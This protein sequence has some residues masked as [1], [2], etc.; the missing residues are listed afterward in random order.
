MRF[1]RENIAILFLCAY[2][3]LALKCLTHFY[4]YHTVMLKLLLFRSILYYNLGVKSLFFDIILS[5]A[6]FDRYCKQHLSHFLSFYRKVRGI[7]MQISAFWSVLHPSFKAI[8]RILVT[9]SSDFTLFFLSI[10][11]CIFQVTQ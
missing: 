11:W 9:L 10:L 3:F 2:Y 5:F 7:L 1:F 8:F 6:L 4:R